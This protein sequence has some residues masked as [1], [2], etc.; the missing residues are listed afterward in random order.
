[1]INIKAHTNGDWVFSSDGELLTVRDV[2]CLSQTIENYVKTWWGEV[3]FNTQ[4]GI[5]WNVV[6]GNSVSSSLVETYL[7]DRI[8]EVE[9][10]ISVPDLTVTTEG[11]SL[12][13][14]AYIQT[15]YGEAEINAS[16]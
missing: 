14:T 13:Y 11:S 10:V 1:M 12:L 8:L 2:D 5:R 4:S 16:I 15:I 7:R 9:G 3:I 6:F